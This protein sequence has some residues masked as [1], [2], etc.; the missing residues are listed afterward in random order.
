MKYCILIALL[1]AGCA[2]APP[3]KKPTPPAPPLPKRVIKAAP[4]VS[5]KGREVFPAPRQPLKKTLMLAAPSKPSQVHRETVV[6]ANVADGTVQVAPAMV[7]T[8]TNAPGLYQ[9]DRSTDLINWT[10]AASLAPWP[11]LIDLTG[12]SA[13]FFRLTPKP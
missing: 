12:D 2:T 5:P 10:W 1:V 9:I 4:A 11:C 3:P 13:A 7:I 6:L 8:F